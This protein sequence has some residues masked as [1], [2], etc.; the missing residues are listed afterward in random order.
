MR[1]KLVFSIL[2]LFCFFLA[3]SALAIFANIRESGAFFVFF[4]FL[5]LHGAIELYQKKVLESKAIK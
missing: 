1:K 4:V 2:S 3:M 5:A